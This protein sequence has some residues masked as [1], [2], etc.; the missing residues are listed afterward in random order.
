MTMITTMTSMITATATVST[1]SARSDVKSVPA[2]TVSY[3][4]LANRI[5]GPCESV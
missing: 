1:E 2:S 3:L 4:G 5:V